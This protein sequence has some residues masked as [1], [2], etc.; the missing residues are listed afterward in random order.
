MSNANRL[1]VFLITLLP[2]F[3]TAQIDSLRTVWTNSE[4]SD[5]SRLKAIEEYHVLTQRVLPDSALKALDV[6]LSLT[7]QNGLVRK[8]AG[9]YVNKA[10][11]F[12]DKGD[13]DEALTI[14]NKAIEKSKGN[15]I[16]YN[17]L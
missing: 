12:R 14:Y 13:L 9:A 1:A 11:I 16:K 3:G 6:Y 17:K 4:S 15:A 7:K 5:T 2:F 8:E 10:N